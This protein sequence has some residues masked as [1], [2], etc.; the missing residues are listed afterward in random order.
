ME[1]TRTVCEIQG[2]K[3]TATLTRHKRRKTIRYTIRTR[4]GGIVSRSYETV[5]EAVR[6]LWCL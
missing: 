3:V 1:T 5:W 4:R 2:F 6:V